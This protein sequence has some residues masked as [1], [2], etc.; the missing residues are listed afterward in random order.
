MVLTVQEA[1]RRINDRGP[2]LVNQVDVHKGDFMVSFYGD[3]G[4]PIHAEEFRDN[5]GMWTC[6]DR[7]E[8]PGNGQ[9]YIPYEDIDHIELDGEPSTNDIWVDIYLK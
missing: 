6:D 7:T 5:L 2:A 9:V 8:C 1:V 3:W 4:Q